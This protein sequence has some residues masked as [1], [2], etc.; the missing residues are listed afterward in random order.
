LEDVIGVSTGHAHSLAVTVAGNVYAWGDAGYGR[1][2]DGAGYQRD[3]GAFGF[4]QATPARVL[5]VDGIGYLEN[6]VA[7]SAGR[8]FSLALGAEGHVFA[9]GRNW[10]GQLG[11]GR[12]DFRTGN[13][14]SVPVRVRGV[15]DNGYLENIAAISAGGEHSLA[16][17]IDGAVYSWGRNFSGELGNGLEWSRDALKQITPVS[18]V[19]VTGDGRL[20]DIL[21]V[22]SGE[23]H[24]LALTIDG[25]I[26]AWGDNLRGQR[27]DGD[28]F[29]TRIS[30]PVLVRG[31]S[32]KGRLQDI[33][34]VDATVFNSYA[35][36]ADGYL[37][38]WGSGDM[39]QLGDGRSGR[40]HRTNTPLRVR[41]VTDPGLPW[42]MPL[43]TFTTITAVGFRLRNR[44]L[45]K[46][47]SVVEVGSLR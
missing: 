28:D 6:I 38:A 26:Y 25:T 39:G 34:A 24:S 37:Y 27:G 21:S 17:A 10:G 13:S 33:I 19:G 20:V 41:G 29:S 8:D 9:W 35:V 40:G 15:G 45:A 4:A 42:A 14:S 43:A 36:S 2:G 31:R 32:E 12:G 7:V 11:N 23:A 44:H 16:V 5:G 22:S 1:L 46:V 3:Y 18:V 30:A 47:R